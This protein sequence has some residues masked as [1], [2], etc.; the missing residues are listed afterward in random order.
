MKYLIIALALMITACG[1]QEST[2]S[3]STSTN[4]CSQHPNLGTWENY[5]TGDI[6]TL[7]ANCSGTSSVCESEFLFSQ[8]NG[9]NL[10][11]RVTKTNSN[12]GCPPIGDKVCTAKVYL[13]GSSDPSQTDTL[14]GF[15]CD[16]GS[17]VLVY[18]KK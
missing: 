2:P 3:P 5:D 15:T 18:H 12:P 1:K 17:N 10:T 14:L 8:P 7:K 11:V 9:N 6:L 4:Q 16:N 13:P